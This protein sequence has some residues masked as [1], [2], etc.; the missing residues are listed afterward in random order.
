M[1]STKDNIS[2]PGIVEQVTDD[3]I[4]VKIIAMSACSS[5]HAKGMCNVADMEEKVIEV[6]KHPHEDLKSGD[7]VRVT[8]KTSQGSKAVLLGY[9]FP[10]FLM[11]GILLLVLFLSEDEGLAGLSAILILIPY[12][13]LLYIYRNKLKKTFSFTID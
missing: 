4:I 3:K 2:H 10:F 7:E 1:T 8:M 13:W 12:Y 6:K 5:C 11:I 9:I